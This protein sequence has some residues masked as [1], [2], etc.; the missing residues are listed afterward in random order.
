M[1]SE[2]SW[3]VAMRNMK[4]IGLYRTLF[5]TALAASV[6]GCQSEP[7]R[8]DRDFGASVR[9]AIAVQTADPTGYPV[10]T[11]G[12]KGEAVLQTYRQ[13]VA[14]PETVERELTIHFGK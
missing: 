10:G 14:K 11:D 3:S 4:D 13:D 9:H 5:F 6:A 12:E 1:T 7:S 2:R 8:V